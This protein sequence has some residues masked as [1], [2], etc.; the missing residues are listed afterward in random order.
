MN[1]LNFNGTKTKSPINRLARKLEFRAGYAHLYRHVV[2]IE[3][4]GQ[5]GTYKSNLTHFTGN[6]YMIGF[7]VNQ[8]RWFIP[9]D[10]GI[11]QWNLKLDATY[12]KDYFFKENFA[13]NGGGFRTQYDEYHVKYTSTHTRLFLSTG[14]G[15]KLFH[16]D[17]RFNLIPTI[18]LNG[19]VFLK[20]QVAENT[21]TEHN[22]SEGTDMPGPYGD[23]LH[24]TTYSYPATDEVLDANLTSIRIG[25]SLS[26]VFRFQINQQWIVDLE[27]GLLV[28]LGSYITYGTVTDKKSSFG[29]F[30]IG[31]TIPLKD[32]KKAD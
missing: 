17:S 23:F 22:F 20:N 6:Q 15:A 3:E 13:G 21:V 27:L 5:W 29:N 26:N 32:A 14:M 8:G 1:S 10:V 4:T 2:L 7:A 31:Y 28:D 24:D 25:M 30:S 16:P 18:R 11:T 9:V 19:S 12:R